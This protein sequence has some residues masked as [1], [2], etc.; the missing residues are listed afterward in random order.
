MKIIDLLNKIAK[1]ELPNRTKFK[2]Y[3]SC[4]D[5]DDRVFVCEY[6]ESYPGIIW[7]INNDCKFN[8]KIYNMRILNY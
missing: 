3:S 5:K 4:N 8:Y 1:G 6:D 7:C 2:V